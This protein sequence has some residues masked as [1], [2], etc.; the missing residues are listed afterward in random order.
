[1]K[2]QLD[3]MQL[4]E[5]E[6]TNEFLIESYYHMYHAWKEEKQKRDSLEE[7]WQ[8]VFHTLLVVIVTTGI[9]L[10]LCTSYVVFGG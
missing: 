3:K 10:L 8:R 9:G 4:E 2:D 7:E 1:M 5:M 6:A